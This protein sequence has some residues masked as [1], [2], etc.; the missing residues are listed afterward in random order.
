MILTL[1]A[2]NGVMPIHEHGIMKEHTNS[3]VP[4]LSIPACG[5]VK[6]S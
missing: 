6:C 4:F 5:L 1:L 3:C 2:F